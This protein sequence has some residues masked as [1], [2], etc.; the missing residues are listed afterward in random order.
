[1]EA[2]IEQIMHQHFG[3]LSFKAGQKQI[4]DNILQGRDTLGIM[5]TGGGK[6]LCY[7]LPALVLPGLTLV[8]SPLIALMKDQVDALN[9]QGIPA[10]YVNSSL[11]RSKFYQRLHKARQGH[12]KLLYAA[13]ERLESE[14]FTELLSEL[15]LSLVAVDEAHCISQWG[16]DFRPSY[17]GIGPWIA[18]L[19]ERPVVAAFTATA[20]P[21]VREDMIKLLELDRPLI[22]INSFKRT[23][24]YLS[25]IKGTDRTR[26][27]S[28]Y[29]EEHPHHPGIVYAATRKEVESLFTELAS[30]GYAVGKYHAGLSNAER[31]SYQEAF[32]YDK[33][34]VMVATNAFGLGINKSNVRFVVHHN[35]PRHL[36]AYYQEAGRA[37]RDGQEADCILLY[38][39][40]D[41]Q[42][43]KFLIEQGQL[44]RSHQEM[45][46]A[47]LQSMIDY[48]HTT[49]CLHQFILN[50]FGEENI[51]EHCDKCANCLERE[52]QDITIEAQKI[53]SCIVRMK[54]AYGSK[55]IASVLKGSQQKRIL[56]LGFDRL[57]TYG[58]MS[59]LS[60]VQIMDLINLLAAEDYLVISSGKYP[61]VQL[62]SR[63]RPVLR[64]QQKIIVSLPKIPEAA[65]PESSLF[66]ALRDLRR[67]IAQTQGLP[68]YVIF[69]DA[70][71]RDMAAYRP[72][73]Q[74]AMLAITGVG[75]IKYEK[76][77]EQ[78]LNIISRHTQESA[79]AEVPEPKPGAAG[80]GNPPPSEEKKQQT[81]REKNQEPKT[82][83]H[84]L[85]WQEYQAGKSLAAI[86]AERNLSLSTIETHLL[87]AAKEGYT[88]NWDQFLSPREESRILA[89][90]QTAGTERLR[91]I[92]DSLPETISYFAIRIALFKNCLGEWGNKD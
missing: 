72:Q 65:I 44:S 62:S 9:D 86:A 67:Q 38:Q 27:I 78:F 28:R 33:I 90:A 73:N 18:A 37:G 46:Y 2:K 55:L 7:Q 6:S 49:R 40:A 30:R 58:I 11:N 79:P 84:L 4:I 59:D 57:S 42:I 83:T 23:N 48:C 63:A 60:T 61:V 77:G 56:E 75:Q 87:R 35:M 8:V 68:P 66:Q 15:P 54:Q 17:L 34:Q 39:A 22:S 19:P 25:V 14:G 80:S 47:K 26:F 64:G 92:K 13:P 70:T 1:M 36:E 24:L 91:P 89:A 45:E 41:I 74:E 32:I 85:S 20:T 16:H 71:L 29:L 82:P 53:F 3:F 12:Y 21:Q 31:D 50:Y 52:L 81:S 88:V 69:P 76:Y 10:S 43:Q 51:L 5:P